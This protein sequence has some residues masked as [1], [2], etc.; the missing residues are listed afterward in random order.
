MNAAPRILFV[1][2]F[3]P[4]PVVAHHSRIEFESSEPR[5][6]AGEVVSVFW[7]NPHVHLR[8]RSEGGEMWD[9]EGADIVSL[10]RR[11]LPRDI[12]KVGDRVRAAGFPSARRENFLDIT[13]VLLPG[14]T[15]AVFSR[16]TEP[17]WS[18]ETVGYAPAPSGEPSR[19][20][21]S[22]SGIFRVWQR[23]RINLP[24][25]ADLPLTAAARAYHEAYEP[26]ADDPILS[27]ARNRA[28]RGS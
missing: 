17:R 19:T 9:L 7:R 3:L 12:V 18:D 23:A 21:A 28:C 15:E 4:P 11:G 10:D 22:G 25:L 24:E 5:E 27:R 2:L 20:A 13:N 14:G 1:L 26:L 16:R 8:I 6:I